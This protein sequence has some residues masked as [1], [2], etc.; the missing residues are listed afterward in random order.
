MRR[1][2]FDIDP[3]R[4]GISAQSLRS[5]TGFVKSFENSPFQSALAAVVNNAY[6][7]GKRLFRKKRRVIEA[8]ADSDS[9]HRRR[10]GVTPRGFYC[11]DNKTDYIILARCRVHHGNTAHIFASEALGQSRDFKGI[12]LDHIKINNRRSVIAG[13]DTR[14]RIS[15]RFAQISF[16]IRPAYALIDSFAQ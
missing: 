2:S 3:K 12:A 6:G 8:A 9:D 4:S 5:D 13:I 1:V 7:T 14:Q 16:A 10:A 15:D 11:F